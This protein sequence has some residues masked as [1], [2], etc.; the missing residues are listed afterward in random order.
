V[1]LN[2]VSPLGDIVAIP[3]EPIGA[4]CTS[5]TGP[6]CPTARSFSSTARPRSSWA[7]SSSSGHTTATASTDAGRSAAPPPSS[8]PHDDRRPARRLSGSDRRRRV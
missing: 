5:S 8:R 3:L 4:G 2:R 1:T 6:T 7:V